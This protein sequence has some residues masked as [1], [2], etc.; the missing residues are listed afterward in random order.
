[1]DFAMTIEKMTEEHLEPVLEMV[2]KFYQSNAVS[3]SVPEAIIYRAFEEAVSGSGRLDGYVILEDGTVKGFAYVTSFYACETG[4][5]CIMLE[6][7]YLDESC[8]GKGYG[9][10][11]FDFLFKAYPS[12]K[13]FRL[14]VTERNEK[15]RKLYERIGFQ[16]LEYEQMI[17]DVQNN[18]DSGD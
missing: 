7:I 6:E 15:A 10:Q 4:G 14:E 17:K 11:F 1:M 12:A 13:R 18:E 5:E 9:T 3:H 8:R 2:R 16:G